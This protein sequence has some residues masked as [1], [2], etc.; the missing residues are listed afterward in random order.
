LTKHFGRTVAVDNLSC[1]ITPGRVTG[2]LGPN[3]PGKTTTMRMTLDLD[4]PTTGTVTVRGH[5][6]TDLPVPMREVGTLL[7]ARAAYGGRTAYNHLLCLAQ[8]NGI[9]KRRVVIRRSGSPPPFVRHSWSSCWLGL[10]RWPRTTRRSRGTS[11]GS[12]LTGR[13]S[14]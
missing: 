5:R 4:A 6:Y 10:K 2:F 12:T 11:S 1:T 9:P 13:L 8:S 3:G 7:D 14:S